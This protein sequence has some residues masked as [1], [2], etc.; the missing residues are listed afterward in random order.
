MTH[1][2][3][4]APFYLIHI[5]TYLLG[6]GLLSAIKSFTKD[7]GWVQMTFASHEMEFF[8]VDFTSGDE[9]CVKLLDNNLSRIKVSGFLL[10][11]L[12]G[13]S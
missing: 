10:L 7:N 12:C 4:D 8:S 6:Y 1:V 11:E 9:V 3:L 5:P 13:L 2:I